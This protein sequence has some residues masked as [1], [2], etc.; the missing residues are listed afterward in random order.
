MRAGLYTEQFCFLVELAG[1]SKIERQKNLDNS[2]L[3]P[4]VNPDS[5]N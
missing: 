4:A 3:G 5:R 2:S 1:Q